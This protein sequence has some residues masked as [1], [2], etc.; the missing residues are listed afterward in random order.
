MH[1]VVA[2]DPAFDSIEA[3]VL[4]SFSLLLAGLIDAAVLAIPESTRPSSPKI[5]ARSRARSTI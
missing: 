2:D 1:D 3:S 5:C 4:P